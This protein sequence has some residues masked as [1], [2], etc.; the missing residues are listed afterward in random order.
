MKKKNQLAIIT[1]SV[2]SR[3]NKT[4]MLAIKCMNRNSTIY[5][6]SITTDIADSDT[7]RLKEH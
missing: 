4:W 5:S 1:L 2:F 7:L 6:D 3:E